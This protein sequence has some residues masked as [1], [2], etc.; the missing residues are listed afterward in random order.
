MSEKLKTNFGF[1]TNLKAGDIILSRDPKSLVSKGV[2]AATNGEFSHAAIYLGRYWVLEATGIGISNYSIQN[3]GV[4]DIGNV[5]VLRLDKNHFVGGNDTL[6]LDMTKYIGQSYWKSGAVKSAIKANV[7]C[8]SVSKF[9]SQLVAEIYLENGIDL[10]TGLAPENTV[11]EDINNS[12]LL[13]DVTTQVLKPLE[14]PCTLLAPVDCSLGLRPQHI[15]LQ[16]E[17]KAIKAINDIFKKYSIRS[18]VN[19]NDFLSIM[20]YELHHSQWYLVDNEITDALRN[21]NFVDSACIFGQVLKEAVM[22]EIESQPN[23][24]SLSKKELSL[25]YIKRLYGHIDI[26]ST[27]TNRLKNLAFFKEVSSNLNNKSSC[28]W[29]RVYISYFENHIKVNREHLELD[30]RDFE[31][32]ESQYIELCRK[33][34]S[35]VVYPIA[36]GKNQLQ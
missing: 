9:C 4:N 14:N 23:I 21:I 10:C 18:A 28:N 15:R 16:S 2:R 13:I 32:L 26:H 19:I 5:K 11:P 1:T 36:F 12:Y 22:E 7:E 20:F 33:E 24:L 8:S 25:T 29:L 3:R 27:F 31:I 34:S 35:L 17:L 30:S 6:T